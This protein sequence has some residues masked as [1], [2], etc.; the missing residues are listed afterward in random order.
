MLLNDCSGRFGLKRRE[1]HFWNERLSKM[2]YLTA[3]IT[4]IHLTT[5]VDALNKQCSLSTSSIPKFHLT[6]YQ[7]S[8]V[9]VASLWNQVQTTLNTSRLYAAK[10]VD[11]VLVSAHWRVLIELISLRIMTKTFMNKH[12]VKYLIT[13][14]SYVSLQSQNITSWKSS[15]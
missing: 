2:L 1:K 14:K 8:F 10:A 15:D 6:L 7:E 5:Y 9:A 11:P 4:P 13:S 12:G 3:Q